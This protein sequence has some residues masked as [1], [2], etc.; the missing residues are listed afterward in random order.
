MPAA[1]TAGAAFPDLLGREAGEA[2]AALAKVFR[3]PSD[4]RG[5]PDARASIEQDL[6]A[7][8]VTPSR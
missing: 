7:S 1:S 6:H 5:L 3:E 8:S 4:H 2:N